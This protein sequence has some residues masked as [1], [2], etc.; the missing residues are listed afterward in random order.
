MKLHKE[1][2]QV[3]LLDSSFADIPPP[4]KHQEDDPQDLVP[5]WKSSLHLNLV[6]DTAAYNPFKGGIPSEIAK[7]LVVDWNTMT[8][9]PIVYVS[10]FWVLKKDM[11]P[12]N[13][14]LAGS[15]LNLTLNFQPFLAYY[16]Q[17][18]TSFSANYMQQQ[19]MG[20]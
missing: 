18:Q 17:F 2:E 3:N 19:E 1:S 6:F 10:D 20:L 13:Q 4:K 16:Y 5:H 14:T 11:V 9:Q 7:N 8:Y 12:L 15:S